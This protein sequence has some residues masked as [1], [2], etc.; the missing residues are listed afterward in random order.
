MKKS[1]IPDVSVRG[2]L[3]SRRSFP[4]RA[5]WVLRPGPSTSPSRLP[6]AEVEITGVAPGPDYVWVPG[7]HVWRGGNY[8]WDPGRYERAPRHGARWVHGQWRHH[9]RGWYWTDGHWK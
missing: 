4:R 1:S 8:V 7:H 5:S 2:R 3:L 6:A 9:E